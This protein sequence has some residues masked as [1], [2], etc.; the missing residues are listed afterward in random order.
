MEG[1]VEIANEEAFLNSL[2]I[3]WG[4]SSRWLLSHT[5]VKPWMSTQ[6]CMRK[7]I[8]LHGNPGS[9]K[10][11]LLRDFL[12]YLTSQT[13]GIDDET[14]IIRKPIFFF[15]DD[16][17]ISRNSS[18]GFVR[19]AIGQI[20]RDKRIKLPIRYLNIRDILQKLNPADE[21]AYWKTLYTIIQRSRGV[22]YLFVIDAID[23]VLRNV[24]INTVTIIDRLQELLSLDLSGRVRLLVSDRKKRVYGFQAE[25]VV[26][27]DVD[28]EVTA[29]SVNDFV[30]MRLHRGF[31]MS[32]ISPSAGKDVEKKIIE[33]AQGNFLHANLLLEQFASNVQ[34][35]DRSQIA[36]GL[37]RLDTLS[38]NLAASYCRLLARIAQPYRRRAKSSFALLRVCQET[39][40]LQQLSFFATL[41]EVLHT[42]PNQMASLDVENLMRQRIDFEDF[43]RGELG[44]IIREAADGIVSFAHVSIKDLFTEFSNPDVRLP[45]PAAALKE[46][47]TS[48]AD[49]HSIFQ[50]LCFTTFQLEDRSLE[51]WAT[52]LE[53]M[54]SVGI[55]LN[56]ETVGAIKS[57]L[58]AISKTPCMAYA[59]A[60]CLEHFQ[61][62]S[63]MATTDRYAV[64]VL[65]S[66]MGYVIYVLWMLLGHISSPTPLIKPERS[67]GPSLAHG[68]YSDVVLSRILARGDFPRLVQYLVAKGANVNATIPMQLQGNSKE[69]EASLL[70]WAIICQQRE[71][72]D[73]MLRYGTTEIVSGPALAPS[74]LHFAAERSTRLYF[75]RRLL[76][77]PGCNANITYNIPSSA[78]YQTRQ[79]QGTPLY[80]AYRAQNT[81]AVE[82]LLAHPHIDI[83]AKGGTGESPYSM[84]FEY[85]MWRYL[86]ERML[87]LS[88]KTIEE[89]LAENVSGI[90]R[91]FSAGVYGWTDMEEKILFE[92]PRQ[93]L[94]V[95]PETKMSPLTTYAYFGRKDKLLWIL[96]RL[97][98]DF[99]LREQND[100]YDL[101]HLC[102]HH[103]WEDIVHLLRQGFGLISLDSDH[104]GRTLLHW[105]IEHSWDMGRMALTD[106]SGHPS[107][108]DKKDHDGLTALHLAVVARNIKAVEALAASGA[109]CLLAD[110]HGNTPAHLAA[111]LG[112]RSALDFFINRPERE[113]GR[114][115][116]GA[117]L[118]HLIS[119][120]FDG[121]TV[122]RFVRTKKAL[123]TVTD[124][125]RLTPLHYAAI[126]NN[127]SA[128][129]VLVNLGSGV[130][131]RSASRTTPLHEAIRSGSVGAALL[132]L[133]LGADYH[134]ADG[135]RQNCLH[136]SCRYGHDELISRLLKLKCDRSVIDVFG[137]HL[138]HRACASNK[139]T[140][141][142]QLLEEDADWTAK[143]KYRRS[144]LDLAVQNQAVY[145]TTTV[146]R[147]LYKYHSQSRSRKRLFDR[148]LR[149]ACKNDGGSEI[150]DLLKHYGARYDGQAA[151][152]TPLE[153]VERNAD[154]MQVV[155]WIGKRP[156]EEERDKDR[157]RQH[158]RRVRTEK[159]KDKQKRRK[160]D[161]K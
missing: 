131:A 41:H 71:S 129:D 3:S 73:L 44:F 27:I 46:F 100:Q 140:I 54:E 113:F 2:P 83:W 72:F 64:S 51:D 79:Y 81:E 19:T 20:L 89:V 40:T 112:F 143:D 33:I 14:S 35:W 31:E 78:N 62:A 34:R 32:N 111:D 133:K 30:R 118:L 161:K 25:E 101:L 74:P 52:I 28:N 77:H 126:A 17:R 151:R 160:E 68:T 5:Y 69:N 120:W 137:M 36:Q 97:P 150:K 43:V 107:L 115:R 76:E 154:D 29:S 124:K 158:R 125:Q 39:L 153:Q 134:A 148:A 114:T 87:Q 96:E 104:T 53:D 12:I 7:V 47:K 90:S 16:K 135:F 6:Q 127:L 24:P 109:D 66:P 10:T 18:L 95:D 105:A 67:H 65:H 146:I 55:D 42:S 49:A 156:K 141:A 22:L 130:N 84:T 61:K 21:D 57:H 37:K 122:R 63:T 88:G 149:V 8:W 157:A 23:E 142:V 155:I 98:T 119:M 45:E 102:A 50:N 139:A 121:T 116:S 11:V 38:H 159:E 70:S 93:L 80:I 85:G 128:V 9:G 108:I 56:L 1:D 138:L 91:I 48:E 145:A 132:L 106:F 75:L 152:E 15:F 92:N 99:P 117:S 13:H 144:P 103:G 123:V 110:K 136:L 82:L 4:H 94:A 60:H 26:T 58:K 86:W 59:V 147:W